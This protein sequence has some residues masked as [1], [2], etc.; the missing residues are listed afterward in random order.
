MKYKMKEILS[1]KEVKK[2]EENECSV[3][4]THEKAYK[5]IEDGIKC[6]FCDKLH[7][8]DT[9]NYIIVGM[10]NYYEPEHLIDKYPAMKCDDCGEFFALMPQKI[11]WNANHDI[12]YTYCFFQFS[13]NVKV[14]IL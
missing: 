10:S 14:T 12:Y 9:E 2:M 5:E 3:C 7:E 1:E 4:F 11:Q 8:P 6:P 13:I